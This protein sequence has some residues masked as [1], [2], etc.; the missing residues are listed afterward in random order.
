MGSLI[1]GK[2]IL[3]ELSKHGYQGYFV[4]GVVRDIII[5]REISDID[6]AT[7][8]PPDKVMEIF[9][10][11]VPIGLKHGTVL[12]LLDGNK[13]EVT[14]FRLDGKYLDF[15]HP[16]DV[17]FVSG[18]EE[19]LS[20]RDFTIN[21]F[22]MDADDQIIDLFEGRKAIAQK[23]IKTVGNPEERFLEDPLRM[24]RAIRFASQLDFTID[25]STWEGLKQSASNLQYISNERI[26]I[27]LDKIMQS[28]YA[29]L[30]IELL[31]KSNLISWI[32]G[33]NVTN[34][35]KLDY[36]TNF[37][38]IKKTSK[39]IERWFL[40]LF[41][42][43]EK[44]RQVVMNTLKFPNRERKTINM[45]FKSYAILNNEINIVNIKKCLI[46]TSDDICLTALN[47]VALI[48]GINEVEKDIYSN[49]LDQIKKDLTVREIKDLE[50]NGSD[51]LAAFNSSAGPWIN[52]I[53]EKLFRQVV[54]NNLTNNKSILLERAIMIKEGVGNGE[55]N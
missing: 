3:R 50:L 25:V 39:A 28:D 8:A 17:K 16:S 10:K 21:A 35:T 37:K 49:Q 40:F 51:L 22:A 48:N 24:L 54:F 32:K 30:G 43:N 18:L 23:L 6:I 20:R 2:R 45:V 29:Y 27:E 36:V 11:T 14:T 46:E 4:G 19:D 13:F 41:P 38:L 55:E 42:L 15:R 34:I 33:L 47:L 9:T 7:D 12:V 31:Y 26:K 53:L 52:I 44:E 5:G 1:I